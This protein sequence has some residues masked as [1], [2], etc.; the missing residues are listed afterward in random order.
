MLRTRVCSLSAWTLFLE[1]DVKD[2]RDRESAVLARAMQEIEGF[3][4]QTNAARYDDQGKQR[5]RVR[6]GATKAE[7]S[8]G[9]MH[10][11]GSP[12]REAEEIV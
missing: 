11:P 5:W 6:V 4:P 1:R 12:E 8:R 2:F 3:V 7:I 9:W 10:L